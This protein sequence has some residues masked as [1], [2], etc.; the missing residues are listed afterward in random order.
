MPTASE[1]GAP[2]WGHGYPTA[3]AAVRPAQQAVRL[4][5]GRGERPR[6]L[7]VREPI[8]NPAKLPAELAG[9]KHDPVGLTRVD[10]FIT[11]D[12]RPATNDESLTEAICFYLCDWLVV[13]NGLAWNLD[14]DG[15]AVLCLDNRGDIADPTQGVARSLETRQPIAPRFV[16]HCRGMIDI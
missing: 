10:A 5:R 4:V 15:T 8:G 11:S 6:Q 7:H 12:D 9:L 1:V 14:H 13:N 16:E 3:A 2:D